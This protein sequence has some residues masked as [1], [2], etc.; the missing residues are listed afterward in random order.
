MSEISQ[1]PVM[2]YA[3]A[4]SQAGGGKSNSDWWP[5]QLKLGERKLNG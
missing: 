5:N 2:G 4:P 3:S 1:C